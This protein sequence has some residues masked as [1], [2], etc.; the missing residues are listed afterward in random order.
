MAAPGRSHHEP[1]DSYSSNS[2]F[3]D[4]S[5]ATPLYPPQ[6][7]RPLLANTGTVSSEGT[8]AGERHVRMMDDETLGKSFR[9]YD[10]ERGQPLPMGHRSK[11]MP[12]PGS[13]GDFGKRRN[14]RNT[15][16]DL[17]AGV[18]K[19]EQGYEQ[20]D[21]RNASSSHLAFAEGD[22]PK[23]KVRQFTFPRCWQMEEGEQW[24]VMEGRGSQERDLSANARTSASW[25]SSITIYSTCQS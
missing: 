10:A 6:H 5:A 11:S 19:F 4:D 3:H 25:R 17:L 23:N 1:E 13:S 16:W 22:V 15:S 9:Q 14:S 18:R 12:E 2:P 7:S 24:R 21:S 8:M 20:F